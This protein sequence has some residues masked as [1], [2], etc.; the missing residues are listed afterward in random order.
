MYQPKLLANNLVFHGQKILY[1][2]ETLDERRLKPIGKIALWAEEES[3][4]YHIEI[5]FN[6]IPTRTKTIPLYLDARLH[7]ILMSL[8]G[9]S[10]QL[11]GWIE[12]KLNQQTLV[13]SQGVFRLANSEL[14]TKLALAR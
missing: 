2:F 13:P 7:A 11:E 4:E 9:Q 6:E 8:V 5:F 1:K 14:I 3:D 12:I 10:T